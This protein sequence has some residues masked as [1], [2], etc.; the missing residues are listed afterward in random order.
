MADAL[1]NIKD[2]ITNLK[3]RIATEGVTDSSGRYLLAL[4]S[5]SSIAATGLADQVSPLTF[6]SQ[7]NPPSG[8]YSSQVASGNAQIGSLSDAASNGDA[9]FQKRI[10][11]IIGSVKEPTDNTQN[12]IDQFNASVQPV[13]NSVN[14]S[15]GK[16]NALKAQLEGYNA[17]Q[18][19]QELQF[20]NEGISSGAIQ[21]RS[22]DLERNNAIRAL[23]IQ[24]QI[25]A[26]QA[27]L[28]GNTALLQ[29]A[30]DK[31]NMVFK[32][33]SDYQTQLYNYQKDLRDAVF[34]YADKQ[35]Q[36]TL[37]QQQKQADQDTQTQKDLINDAQSWAAKASANG[38]MDLAA[39]F[40]NP[41]ITREELQQLAGKVAVTGT[42]RAIVDPAT[43]Q[44]NYY[45]VKPPAQ[46]AST[47]VTGGGESN[48]VISTS[49]SSTPPSYIKAATEGYPG[50]S[51]IDLS[52][53]SSQAQI[54]AAQNYSAKTGTPLLTKDDADKVQSANQSY[55][56]AASLI[57][58]VRKLTKNVVNADNSQT[59]MTF[60][61]FN[62]Q[63]I[64]AAPWSSTNNDAK[65]FIAARESLLSLITRAA[66]EKGVLTDSDVAR[67]ANALPGYYDNKDL[68]TQKA[69][70]LDAVI[71]SVF[72]GAVKAYITNNIGS[73]TS[74]Q[75][76]PSGY[77]YQSTSG[78]T[79]ILPYNQ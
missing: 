11:D 50:G 13:Q 56:S 24:A 45:Y 71:Q 77:Q 52:K 36:I 2:Q 72:Q 55:Q 34:Q 17:E 42:M 4:T 58:Q 15:T 54:V 68:A 41:N 3:N 21:G 49:Q 29:Q 53:L 37:Q 67:I 35:Q 16:I 76:P 61:G 28:T 25:L 74:N 32:I 33:Q 5:P 23:P 27:T 75:P 46:G 66:G 38:Q 70:N 57:E 79:Y 31:L 8:T 19:A 78:N 63:R 60:Q 39:E 1:Q 7:D 10:M 69:A 62:L 40:A 47:G 48:P 12:Y 59:S 22:I 64:A 30:Q 20:K 6:P 43:G 9:D 14:D 65:A 44:I 73:G 51:Y 18:T 26:E